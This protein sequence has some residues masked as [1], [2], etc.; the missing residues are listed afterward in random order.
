LARGLQLNVNRIW[1]IALA[2][3]AGMVIVAAMTHYAVARK[4]ELDARR[5]MS[6]RMNAEST[7]RSLAIHMTVNQFIHNRYE[8][9]EALLNAVDHGDLAEVRDGLQG[10]ADSNA[11]DAVNGRTALMK[12]TGWCNPPVVGALISGGAN[13]NA[14][15]DLGRTALMY[16]IDKGRFDNVRLLLK[17]HAN[18]NTRGRNGKSALDLAH[19][20]HITTNKDLTHADWVAVVD[21]LKKYGAR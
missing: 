13:V 11:R 17:Y 12:A 15:D 2:F 4:S 5:A 14:R 21:L 18:P 6:A 16:A 7:S 10:G 20:E 19:D 9:N 3:G 8:Q 1:N